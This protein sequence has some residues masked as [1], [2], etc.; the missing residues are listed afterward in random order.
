MAVLESAASQTI[1]VKNDVDS[2]GRKTTLEYIATL[3]GK[4]HPVK[5]TVD[6]KPSF[7]SEC[8]GVEEDRRRAHFSCCH[9][10]LP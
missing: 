3:D 6:G 10:T 5:A 9:L 1:S 8:R 4:D 2:R 7:Q